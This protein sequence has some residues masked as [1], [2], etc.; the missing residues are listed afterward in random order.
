MSGSPGKLPGEL[1]GVS[2]IFRGPAAPGIVRE[3]RTLAGA[4]VGSPGKIPGELNGLKAVRFGFRFTRLKHAK[5]ERMSRPL[6]V[7][8]PG[9]IDPVLSCPVPG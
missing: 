3:R 8:Y 1:N 7:E 2:S 5:L 6:R 9:A 4:F